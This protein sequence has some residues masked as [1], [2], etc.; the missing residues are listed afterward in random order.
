MI[1]Y[2]LFLFPI[3]FLQTPNPH[4]TRHHTSVS[5]GQ[6]LYYLVSSGE[7]IG[8]GRVTGVSPAGKRLTAEELQSLDDLSKTLG[9]EVYTFHV[10]ALVC[11]R[12]DLQP[13]VLRP[14]IEG[15]DRYVFQ[16]RDE[17][18]YDK[19]HYQVGQRYL[20]VFVPLANQQ[21][22]QKKYKLTHDVIYYEAFEE[23]F[24]E[25]RGLVPLT[26]ANLPWINKLRIFCQALAPLGREQKLRALRSLST[27]SDY[28]LRESA[29]KAIANIEGKKG[30]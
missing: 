17:N 1:F 24:D 19:A 9:G 7:F 2:T 13:G 12:T 21:T 15:R 16:R 20:M 4:S 18:F 10:E 30:R 29:R 5:V 6:E 23:S 28:E 8:V 11:A 25:G 14:K 27:S 3:L 26:D 22:L